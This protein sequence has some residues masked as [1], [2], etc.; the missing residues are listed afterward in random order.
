VAVTLSDEV[1]AENIRQ[2]HAQKRA[3]QDLYAAQWLADDN[4]KKA[5][6]KLTTAHNAKLSHKDAVITNMK[7][8]AET[9]EGRV[10]SL[11]NQIE[12]LFKAQGRR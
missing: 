7:D 2:W 10:K 6:Q 1:I 3:E 11:E 4:A 12:G 8:R 9:A 5:A